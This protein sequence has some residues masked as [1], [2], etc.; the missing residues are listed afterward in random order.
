MQEI[1]GEGAEE[2]LDRGK[3]LPKYEKIVKH[4]SFY[5]EIILSCSFDRKGA[6]ATNV[7]LLLGT[8][9]PQSSP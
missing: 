4:L 2:N 9:A 8:R 5:S 1:R 6:T 3:N 7:H